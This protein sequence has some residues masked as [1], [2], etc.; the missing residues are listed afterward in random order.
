MTREVLLGVGGGVAAFK[1]AALASQLVQRGYGVRVAM[2]K[3]ANEFVGAVTFEGLTGRPVIASSTQVDRDGA[4]P[5][6]EATRA[7]DV[8]VIVPA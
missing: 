8:L 6:I 2:T 1:A 4:G 3:A 5:H 7:A